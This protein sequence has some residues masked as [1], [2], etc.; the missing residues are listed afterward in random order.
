MMA[1]SPWVGVLGF[2][3]GLIMFWPPSCQIVVFLRFLRLS[4]FSAARDGLISLQ[5][6]NTPSSSIENYQPISITPVLPK[7]IEQLVSLHLG[8]L[9]ELSIMLLLPILPIEEV[10][11][12][13]K[14]F[15]VCVSVLWNAV[16]CCHCWRGGGRGSFRLT[17]VHPFTRLTIRKFFFSCVLWENEGLSCQF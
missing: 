8:L 17:S 6:Q 2:W 16:D 13:R 3:R 9:M 1:V 7:V 15:C 11:V 4:R 5:F 12:H 14:P 10:L